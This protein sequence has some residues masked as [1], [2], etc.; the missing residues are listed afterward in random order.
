[1]PH[2]CYVHYSCSWCCC[3][4]THQARLRGED[5]PTL[6]DVVLSDQAR[7]GRWGQRYR[8]AMATEAAAAAAAAGAQMMAAAAGPSD[9]GSASSAGAGPA[10]KGGLLR[11]DEGSQGGVAAG[12]A[13][14]LTGSGKAGKAAAAGT[15]AVADAPAGPAEPGDVGDGAGVSSK[16]AAGASQ[17]AG[18][19]GVAGGMR[20]EVE[21]AAAESGLPLD[22]LAAAVAADVQEQEAG[23]W[24]KSL[25]LQDCSLCLD[26][27]RFGGVHR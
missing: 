17:S 24:A 19:G 14:V 6:P 16:T 21:R 23:V 10:G 2:C 20:A 4:A 22:L 26:S 13:A 5:L 25:L 8:A 7:L 15:G 3:L 12:T 1:M 18:Q 9:A 27:V 11:T